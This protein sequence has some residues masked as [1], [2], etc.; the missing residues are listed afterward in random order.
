MNTKIAIAALLLIVMTTAGC[1]D[2]SSAHP[3]Q[4]VS[5]EAIQSKTVT[6]ATVEEPQQTAEAPV[7]TAEVKTRTIEVFFRPAGGKAE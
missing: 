5:L 3:A 7:P 2:K 4:E 1:A 6:A